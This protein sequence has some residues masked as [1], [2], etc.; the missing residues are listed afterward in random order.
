[1]TSTTKMKKKSN[2]ILNFAFGLVTGAFIAGWLVFLIMEKQ[3]ETKNQIER[4]T[5]HEIHRNDPK[6]ILR[7]DNAALAYRTVSI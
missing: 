5:N 1:M 2:E 3:T 6:P 7:E 4:N